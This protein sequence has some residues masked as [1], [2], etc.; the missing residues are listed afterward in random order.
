MQQYT[1]CLSRHKRPESHYMRRL[2]NAVNVV[3]RYSWCGQVSRQCARA[4]VVALTVF[5]SATALA[6][7]EVAL[8][9]LAPTPEHEEAVAGII[10][11]MQRYHYKRV[12][13]NDQL[14]EQIFE[15]YL[16]SLDPQKSFL[17]ASDIAEFDQ[18]R[19]GFDD[20][21]SYTHLTLPTILLV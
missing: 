6:D 13:V 7:R 11:L 4:L 9:S 2:I 5:F 21:V 19:R 16:E 3:A 17:L 1:R 14:S 12:R 8:D 10:Q 15:R 20:A 18:Y